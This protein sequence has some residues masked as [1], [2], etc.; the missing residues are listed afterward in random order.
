M[1]IQTHTA[2]PGV[3]HWLGAEQWH[4][5][6]T[7]DTRMNIAG[8]GFEWLSTPL[9]LF[10]RTDRFLFLINWIS[11]LLLPG[12]IF[13]V[14]TRLQVRP[15]AAWWW[16][17]LLASGWC[18]VFQAESNVNDSFATIYALAA[19]DLALRAR[20]SK[21]VADLWL[22]ILAAGLLTGTKQTSIPLALLWLIAV[23][24]AVRQMF[25]IPKRTLGTLAVAVL[26]LLVSAVPLIVLNL[27]HT[28]NWM[29]ISAGNKN[30]IVGRLVKHGSGFSVLGDHRQ[31][32]LHRRPESQAAAFSDG[33]FL[34]HRH[35][36]FFAHAAGRAFYFV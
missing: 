15:R 3:L 9:I 33:G 27:V 18:F 21:S 16:M 11:F 13:S 7:S 29:G 19:V 2:F 32:V 34:E 30:I 6:H 31:H 4:W 17:W 5:I 28:G 8:C 20:E 14:F 10:T 25:S 35:A 1:E 36:T 24:P 22:S 26:G 12:L 23:W